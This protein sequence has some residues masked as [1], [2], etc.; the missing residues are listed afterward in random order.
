M[1]HS[2]INGRSHYFTFKMLKG[3]NWGYMGRGEKSER[4]RENKQRMTDD[5]AVVYLQLLITD[6]SA[7]RFTEHLGAVTDCFRDWP[8]C[9][10]RLI[11]F[12]SLPCFGK[13]GTFYRKG[14]E[15]FR[16]RDLV[17]YAR[18]PF[19]ALP[20]WPRSP[21]RSPP[22]QLHKPRVP[23]FDASAAPARRSRTWATARLRSRESRTTGTGR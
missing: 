22:A 16:A 10:R 5:T 3:N 13:F 9:E 2:L 1:A 7:F 11:P 18:V 4:E 20:I 23:E 14:S 15:L 17:S 19:R 6:I 12:S 21:T 8:R